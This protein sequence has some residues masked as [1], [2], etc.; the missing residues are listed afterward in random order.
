MGL[1]DILEGKPKQ[2]KAGKSGK[3]SSAK[4]GGKFEKE[5]AEA[6]SIYK[7][8]RVAYIQQF[9]PPTVWIPARNGKPGGLIHARKTGF[10]FVG[11][12]IPTKEP[13]FIECKT[14][15]RGQIEV[16]QETTGIKL[17]QLETLLWLEEVAG[18]IAFVLWQIRKADNLVVKIKPSE[19]LKICDEEGR[20]HITL[21]DCENRRIPRVIRDIRGFYDFLNLL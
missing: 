15:E 1:K 4:T 9:F 7:A 12:I 20:K 5:I 10:D 11:V 6:C 14:T 3:T 16:G 17:H 13:V 2:R 21:M 19:I 18:V 8:N